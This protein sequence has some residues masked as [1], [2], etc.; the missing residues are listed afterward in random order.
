MPRDDEICM[1][2]NNTGIVKDETGV[3][4]CWDCLKNGKLD[5]YQDM[6]KVN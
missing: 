4:V 5:I 3:H 1:K 2:C 6:E